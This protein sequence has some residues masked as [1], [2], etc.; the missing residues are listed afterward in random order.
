MRNVFSTSADTKHF[1]ALEARQMLA[2]DLEISLDSLSV[3][4][5][6]LVP[7]DKVKATVVVENVGDEP[8]FG[9][10]DLDIGVI[11][12]EETAEHELFGSRRYGLDLAPGSFAL[13]RN[14][15]VTIGSDFVPGLYNFYAE[16]YVPEGES[17]NPINDGNFENNIVYSERDV[18]LVYR[19]GTFIGNSAGSTRSNVKLVTTVEAGNP[20]TGGSANQTITYTLTGGG[21]GEVVFNDDDSDDPATLLLTNTGSKSAFAIAVKG[22][23]N[24]TEFAGPIEVS[25]SLKSFKAPSV[26]FYASRIW[27]GGSLGE[28]TVR[29]I[30]SVELD[31]ETR[32]S[33][34]KVTAR[35]VD[36]FSIVSASAISTL[37]VSSWISAD[38]E[39]A[40]DLPVDDFVDAPYISSL[41]SAGAFQPVLYL[42]GSF[43]P[44]GVALGKT[45]I[46]GEASGFWVLNGGAAAISVGSTNSDFEATINGT[47]AAFTSIGTFAGGLSALTMGKL[48]FKG[49]LIGAGISSGFWLGEDLSF[50]GEGAEADN[51]PAS[52]NFGSITSLVVKGDVVDSLISAGL[53]SWDGESFEFT[54]GQAAAIRKITI[55][56]GFENSEFYGQVFPRTVKIGSETLVPAD[57]PDIFYTTVE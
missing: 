55:S 56:G 33:A 51:V 35:H 21:Y 9:E 50:G 11:G 39:D 4:Y 47:L 49:D 18:E 27:V 28:F 8:A 44:K 26:D 20:D 46:R 23:S 1:D 14:I 52:S 42:N 30:E 53:Y 37:K 22:G 16:I 19:F 57:N 36:N 13:Y 17:P 7:G 2:A 29:D 32:G 45:T 40:S 25:G 12:V 34:M 48:D 24:S 10:F 6:W 41:T 38:P 15:T 54:F 3:P 31:V 5:E 43:A